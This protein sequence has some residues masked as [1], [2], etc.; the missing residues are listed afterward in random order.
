[1]SCGNAALRHNPEDEFDAERN[2]GGQSTRGVSA[3]ALLARHKGDAVPGTAPALVSRARPATSAHARIDR[4]AEFD[5][6]ELA[7]TA[8][9]SRAL[10]KMQGSVSARNIASRGPTAPE[11]RDY[12]W[13]DP[14]HGDP[15]GDMRAAQQDSLAELQESLHRRWDALDCPQAVRADFLAASGDDPEAVASEID[16]LGHAA[17]H[18]AGLEDLIDARERA[19]AALEAEIADARAGGVAPSAEPLARADGLAD[20]VQDGIDALRRQCPWIRRIRWKHHPD[21]ERFAA[22]RARGIPAAEGEG[23]RRPPSASASRRREAAT[24]ELG[25]HLSLESFAPTAST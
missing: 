22:Q 7:Q 6:A 25:V 1:V 18:L 21:Y 5:S 10:S 2:R 24:P 4:P 23:G 17:A 14:V 20:A 19:E 8:M 11:R 12:G 13:R 3:G 16:R 15:R 9:W